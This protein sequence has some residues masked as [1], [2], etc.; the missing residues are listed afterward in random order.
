MA[1]AIAI[2]APAAQRQKLGAPLQTQ[3]TS[4]QLTRLPTIAGI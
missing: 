3:F 1:G 2:D 4:E